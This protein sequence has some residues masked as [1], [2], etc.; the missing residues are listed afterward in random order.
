[1]LQKIKEAADFIQ[2]RFAPEAKIAI[3]LGSGLGDFA[4]EIEVIDAV[5]YAEIPNFPVSEVPGHAGR[6]VYGTVKGKKVLAMQGRFH[7]YEGF[8]MQECTIHVRV[9][10]LLGIKHLFV[11]NAAGGLNPNFQVGDLMLI[12]DHINHFGDNPLRGKN[13][14]EFGT[15]FPAMND[16]YSSDLRTIAKAIAAENELTLQEGVYVGLAGP[17]FETQAELKFFSIIGGDAVGMSTVPEV[18][19]AR[20]C[21]MEVFGMSIITNMAVPG[22]NAEACHE[23]VQDAAKITGPKVKLLFEKLI[24]TL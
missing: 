5:P 23:E 1:M 22:L 20:H 6:L 19:V 13:L 7:Y 18:L 14:E 16:A 21:G 8:S 11:S 24:S 9:F 3:V 4:N 15:R 2:A 10:S 17:N 12:S